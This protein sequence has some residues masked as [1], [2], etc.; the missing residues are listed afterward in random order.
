MIWVYFGTCT[1]FFNLPILLLFICN[2]CIHTHLF[3]KELRMTYR[4]ESPSSWP[5]LEYTEQKCLETIW[6]MVNLRL[7]M[8]SSHT[9]AAQNL[10]Y[11]C[12]LLPF[13]VLWRSQNLL[14]NTCVLFVLK[15]K[16]AIVC[17]FNGNGK[18]WGESTFKVTDLQDKLS[19]ENTK[20]IFRD[21][22]LESMGIDRKRHHII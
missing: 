17:I 19:W 20:F 1:F 14:K 3:A 2:T 18:L 7:E 6:W 4:L 22:D 9:S 11:I 12:S 13:S 10:Q 16:G 8:R 15:N 5:Y 21:K